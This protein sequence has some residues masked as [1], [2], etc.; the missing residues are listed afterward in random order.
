MADFMNEYLHRVNTKLSYVHYLFFITS[1]F[2]RYC[3]FLFCHISNRNFFHCSVQCMVHGAETDA[4]VM[5][6]PLTDG[7]RS[8]LA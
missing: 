6:N 2:N 8:N 4:G 3:V 1:I 7:P 5:I